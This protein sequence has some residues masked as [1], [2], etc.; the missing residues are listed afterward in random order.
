MQLLATFF[1]IFLAIIFFTSGVEKLLNF[2]SHLRNTAM[3]KII[4][5]RITPFFLKIDIFFQL[6]ISVLLLFGYYLKLAL[7]LSFLFLV[8]YTVAIIVNLLRDRKI[9]CSCGGILGNHEISRKLVF[10]NLF[11]LGIVPFLYLHAERLELNLIS[12]ILFV[13]AINISLLIYMFNTISNF[14]KGVW[15]YE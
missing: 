12:F 4:P 6:L 11:F 10:R 15:E 14:K 5:Q 13:N 1:Q 3:Y 2:K 7:L 9:S 8:V